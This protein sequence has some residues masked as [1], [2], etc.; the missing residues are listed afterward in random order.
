MRCTEIQNFLGFRH[1]LAQRTCNTAT[2]HDQRN[3]QRFLHQP[4]LADDDQR[5]IK[6]EL[7]NGG[8]MVSKSKLLRLNNDDKITR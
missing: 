8:V 2:S 4:N 3:R 6:N 5:A 1:A 7:S